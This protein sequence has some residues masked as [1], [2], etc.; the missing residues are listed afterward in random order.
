MFGSPFIGPDTPPLGERKNVEPVTQA[1]IAATIAALM[2]KDYVKEVPKAARPIADAT[3]G[4][5]KLRGASAEGLLALRGRTPAVDIPTAETVAFDLYGLTAR[6]TALEGERDRNFRL[7]TADGRRLVLKFIDHEADDVVVD[8][9]SA[10][11]AHLAE[12]NAD[13]GAA[14]G[15][16]H[17]GR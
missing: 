14:T 7:D 17:A 6:A 8:G 2:G 10:A 16:S 1:Q 3:E 12:Q 5:V 13:A 9:Q 15:H 4:K 11:L